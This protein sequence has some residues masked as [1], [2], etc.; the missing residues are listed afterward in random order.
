[1]FMND[2]VHMIKDDKEFPQKL[3]NGI[4]TFGR[5]GIVSNH[6][7]DIS[8]GCHSN[9]A[10]VI[11]QHHADNT[12]IIAIGGNYGT[13]LHNTFGYSHHKPEVVIFLIDLFK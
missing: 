7:N 13:V 5:T 2:A 12:H 1:L 10:T 4:L 9:G 3:Y 8:I 11:D 6:S